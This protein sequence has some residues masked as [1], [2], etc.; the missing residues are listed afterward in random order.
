VGGA[1]SERDAVI[2][3]RIGLVTLGVRDLAAAADFYE[4]LGW[5]R[6][7]DAANGVVLFE[8]AGARLA[9]YP[10]EALARSL[11]GA[12]LPEPGRFRG[13]ALVVDLDG[14]DAVDAACETA[15][16]AGA[17]I[18]A[19]PHPTE[20]GGRVCLFADPDGNLW[21]LLGRDSRR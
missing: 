17:T 1:R 7:G 3:A 5:P 6:R 12:A 11:P 9:L 4:R 8:T 13:I 20:W 10:L 2:P 18:V 15:R 16:G 21:E 14:P 19:E